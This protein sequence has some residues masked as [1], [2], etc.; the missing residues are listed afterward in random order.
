MEAYAVALL[1][2]ASLSCHQN[3]ENNM[4]RLRQ[5][6]GGLV[7]GMMLVLL[8]NG[9]AYLHTQRPLSVDFNKT[10]IGTKEGRASSYSVLWLV[11]WGDSGIKA[12]ATN[13]N[14]K[15]ILSAD[16]ELLAVLLGCYT[17]VTTVIYG[18]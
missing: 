6:V 9:C 14:I 2:P 11:A 4:Q 10:E 16:T 1:N 7:L 5:L 8:T 13:G 17:R 3:M 18:D 15:T 12:A